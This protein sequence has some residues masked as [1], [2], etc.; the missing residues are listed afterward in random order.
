[1]YRAYK[2]RDNHLKSFVLF[3]LVIMI[4]TP[5]SKA[6]FNPR[7]RSADCLF[8]NQQYSLALKKYY[9]IY[10]RPKGSREE[11]N[12]IASK[13]ADC[14]RL[15]ENYRRAMA[16]YQHLVRYNWGE[17]HPIVFLRLAD[18]LKMYG[19]IDEA[20][21][22][23]K[24]FQESVPDDSRGK[25]G[26]ESAQQI[27][28][29]IDKPT[30]F[31]VNHPRIINSRS[32][33]FSPAFLSENNNALVFT[34]S[35]KESTGKEL[36]GWTGQKFSDIFTTQQDRNGKW[37][38]PILIDKAENINTKD[39]E[40]NP[41]INDTYNRM[42]YTRCK[43]VSGK[44]TG[45]Q[46]YVSQ[47]VGRTWSKGRPLKFLSI[48]TTVSIGQPTLTKNELTIIFSS[49]KRNSLGG[50]DLWVAKRKSISDPFGHVFNLGS[51]INTKGDELFPFLKNDTVLYFSSNG[52]GG[53]GGLDLFVSKPDSL[54]NW[55]KPVNLRYPMNSTFDDFGIVFEKNHNRGFFSSNRKGVLGKEDIFYFS[56]PEINFTI[57]GT[58]TNNKTLFGLSNV[59]VTLS[60]STGA[61][62]KTRTNDKGYFLFGSSQIKKNKNYTLKIEKD[63][64]LTQSKTLTTKK[65]EMSKDFVANFA[66]SPIPSKPV[67]LPDI[68][69]DLGKWELKTQYQDSLQGLVQ[70]LRNNPGLVIE[71]GSHTDTRG[72][73]EENDILSQ[74]RAKSVVNF[75]I[76]RGIDPQ[77]LVAKGYGER[78]PR[79]L[80]KD[81][82]K[83]G[84]TFKE[85]DVLN[86]DYINKLP[87][88]QAKE[89]AF[90]LNR[91]TDFRILRKDFKAHALS[92]IDTSF[93]I[94]LQ[95]NE[96]EVPFYI[97]KKNGLYVANCFINGLQEPF[98]YDRGNSALISVKK[99]I[100]LLNEGIISKEDFIGN[101]SQILQNNTV[102]NHAI[103]NLK[104]LSI[105]GKTIKNLQI[106][107]SKDLFFDIVFGDQVLKKLGSFEF[108]TKKNLLI[109]HEK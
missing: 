25:L 31:Q 29:W 16:M 74:K 93:Q 7:T 102:A 41:W 23:Y 17:K 107:V 51:N 97:S 105:G 79:T 82:T 64:F 34:S 5:I 77:R 103:L 108:N 61:T 10:R 90:S 3:L 95:Q 6:Q 15:T 1:M 44:R 80:Q 60:D 13:M 104:E 43:K 98:M 38:K 85:G 33:D 2:K 48:D 50:T 24:K 45:C 58:I 55:G 52:H 96:N 92:D 88:L 21:Q 73:E 78:I 83:R 81:I 27:K 91:R 69:Y 57:S 26:I 18:L 37:S 11:R 101:A 62:Y 76:M 87:T 32:A 12:R 67:V 35:R 66:L 40:G 42:Y 94:T 39:N 46:I 70:M 84:V 109:I 56:Q 49:D 47:R 28:E 99:T 36:D 8:N 89:A 100:Q 106:I 19:R 54:G 22:Y 65:L 14:Y 68:L 63:D 75:L 53:M 72:S 20:I 71:L 9:K 4:F 30:N 86:E 59:N